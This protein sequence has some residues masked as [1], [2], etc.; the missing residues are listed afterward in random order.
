[1]FL[2]NGT[3]AELTSNSPGKKLLCAN[4][5]SHTAIKGKP[6]VYSVASS[7]AAAGRRISRNSPRLVRKAITGFK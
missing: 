3:F 6:V 1:M 7:S 2:Q 5:I 4:A